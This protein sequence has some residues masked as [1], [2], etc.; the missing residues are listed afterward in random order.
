MDIAEMG[1]EGRGADVFKVGL[2]ADMAQHL[3]EPFAP[4]DSPT[5]KDA[6]ARERA[7]PDGIGVGAE[8]CL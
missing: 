8:Q 6:L 1:A 3:A 2:D 7:P 4:N 5:P